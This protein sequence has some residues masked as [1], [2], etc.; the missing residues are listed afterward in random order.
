MTFIDAIKACFQNYA[1]FRGR[2]PRA[3][4]WYFALF[5]TVATIVLQVIWPPLASAFNLATLIPTLAVGWRRLHDA[6]R[7]GWWGLLPLASL[8]LWGLAIALKSDGWAYAALAATVLFAII[9]L[10]W[11]CQK[12]SAADNRFGSASA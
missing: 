10:F 1:T 3:E 5:C 4:Y 2:A 8:P 12:G 7:S 9:V 6:G 11:L